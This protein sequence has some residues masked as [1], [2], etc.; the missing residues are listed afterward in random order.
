MK[1]LIIITLCF[2]T[3][4]PAESCSE[5][6]TKNKLVTLDSWSDLPKKLKEFSVSKNWVFHIET[7]QKLAE[8]IKRSRLDLPFVIKSKNLDYEVS[9]IKYDQGAVLS[10]YSRKNRIVSFMLNRQENDLFLY[11]R[12]PD[13]WQ[14]IWQL[15]GIYVEKLRTF[16]A[17]YDWRGF[18]T[19]YMT[20]FA[21]MHGSDFVVFKEVV[22]AQKGKRV[23]GL[24]MDQKNSRFLTFEGYLRDIHQEHGH[25]F[26][27]VLIDR[28][29]ILIP[30]EGI[31]T[32]KT[33]VY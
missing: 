20:R 11:E 8:I 14:D 33:A 18:E 27:R 7:R 25:Y 4:F 29:L 13:D 5:L 31:L 19:K 10:L 17:P 24:A 23:L 1:N 15:E 21:R 22:E 16:S 26:L 32:L 28:E 30:V 3:F 2:A 6:F 9:K 12:Y